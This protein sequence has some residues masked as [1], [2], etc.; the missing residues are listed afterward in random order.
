MSLR[1]A[2]TPEESIWQYCNYGYDKTKYTS[3]EDC[4]AKK[5]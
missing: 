2:T 3:Q 4:I 5:T 1:A